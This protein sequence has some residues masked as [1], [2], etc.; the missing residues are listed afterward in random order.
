MAEKLDPRQVVTFEELLRAW[1]VSETSTGDEGGEK[2][3]VEVS[4]AKAV[5]G[6]PLEIVRRLVRK[7]VWAETSKLA[8]RISRFLGVG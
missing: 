7:K 4:D 1:A 3:I 6:G 5:L 8:G 2:G